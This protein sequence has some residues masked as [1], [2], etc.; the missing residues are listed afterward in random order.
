MLKT[1]ESSGRTHYRPPV[2]LKSGLWCRIATVT[3]P[4]ACWSR[5][6]HTN[7]ILCIV[8]ERHKDKKKHRKM[9]EN[10]RKIISCSFLISFHIKDIKL[11]T[12]CT[13]TQVSP[14]SSQ[15]KNLNYHY[16]N[17][18]SG[19]E[20][21]AGLGANSRVYVSSALFQTLISLGLWPVFKIKASV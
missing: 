8:K 12:L 2:L 19:K 17:Y 10:V 5:L 6:S 9:T 21:T 4:T 7:T 13:L 18:K 1:L 20:E 16:F 11:S 3:S 14:P 15:K